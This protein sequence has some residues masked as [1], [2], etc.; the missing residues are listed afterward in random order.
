MLK[1]TVPANQTDQLLKDI[2]ALKTGEGA[3]PAGG[4]EA[5]SIEVNGQP[6]PAGVPAARAAAAP[7]AG[8]KQKPKN[9]A[10]AR[11]VRLKADLD[12]ARRQLGDQNS[13]VQAL[14]TQ[15]G[16][17]QAQLAEIAK[18]P[19]ET[20]PPPAAPPARVAKPRPVISEGDTFEDGVNN[21]VNW[22]LEELKA[23]NQP[24]DREAIVAEV[25]ATLLKEQADAA[26]TNEDQVRQQK[27]NDAAEKF[28]TAEAG[29][30]ERY[31]DF[32]DAIK[33][34][35]AR[36]LMVPKDVLSV[37]HATFIES[38]VGHDIRY[39][40]AKHPDE[41]SKIAAMNPFEAGRALSRLEGRLEAQMT[42]GAPPAK[43]EAE[44]PPAPP[45]R[46]VVPPPARAAAPQSRAP[47]PPPRIGAG[48]A[49]PVVDLGKAPY[50]VYRQSRQASRQ[51]RFGR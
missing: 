13:T 12:A 26:K 44:I 27:W 10:E 14:Q 22:A 36:P 25:R 32:D 31:D 40:L 33:A 49:A 39:H 48:G 46:A 19:A 51:A 43:P 11:I 18:K 1:I 17:L 20:A 47:Q 15:M 24:V 50:D 23:S 38:A 5:P 2:A 28:K 6:A 8:V 34:A 37:I 45:A 3:A 30:R 9:S 16:T 7:A 21:L 29:A 42:A 35:D 41:F 4:S